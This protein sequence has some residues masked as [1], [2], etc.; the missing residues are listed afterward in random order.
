M[1][2]LKIVIIRD[3]SVKSVTQRFLTKPF[4]S[5]IKMTI[6]VD[7]ERKSFEIDGKR[8]ILQIWEFEF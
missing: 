6:G 3:S 1:I 8:V 5:G 2:T 7:F 4:K